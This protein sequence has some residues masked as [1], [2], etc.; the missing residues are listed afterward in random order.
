MQ[1]KWQRFRVIKQVPLRISR[2]VSYADDNLW[3]KLEHEGI[4]GW[5]EATPISF[6]TPPQT[7]ERLIA[8]L[9]QIVPALAP[10]DPFEGEALARLCKEHELPSA[11]TAALDIARLDWLGKHLKVPLWK[12]WGLDRRTIV[13]TT[14]TIGIMTPDEA[15]ERA[16]QWLAQ[17]PSVKAWKL[18]LG[19]PEGI[20]ADQAMLEAVRETIPE[21]AWLMVDAN[22]GWSLKDAQIMIDWLAQRDVKYVEQPLP[23]GQE[24]D[25]LPLF[26]QASLPLFADESCMSAEDI[27]MLA[28]R[29]HGINIKL[30]KCGGLSEAQK[31][32]HIAKAC[33]LKVM[34]GCFAETL[35]TNTAAAH[36]SPLVDAL[37]LDS[38]LNLTN[39]P[40]LGATLQD[41]ILIPP[42]GPGLGVTRA[43]D[44]PLVTE[45][46]E[47]TKS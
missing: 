10:L 16:R 41:G 40:F 20:E 22:G 4:E 42:D 37:D 47:E 11:A 12:L 1:I 7:T 23:H 2:G 27:P 44:I 28:D 45:T 35:I 25:Y 26:Q 24:E 36:L 14:V 8:A 13:P 21:G 17:V 5:G 39:D 3:V 43:E 34:F 19:N 18:K 15:R 6:T 31:M 33:G 9:E 46:T 29:V 30:L 38:S 32:I